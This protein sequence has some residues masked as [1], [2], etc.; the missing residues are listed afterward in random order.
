MGPISYYIGAVLYFGNIFGC[1]HDN[2]HGYFFGYN[3]KQIS[4]IPV[5]ENDDDIQ[6]GED[7][8]GELVILWY[9]LFATCED[10]E[11]STSLTPESEGLGG[12]APAKSRSLSIFF[13]AF[14]R[15][16]IFFTVFHADQ[17]IETWCWW[18]CSC[19]FDPDIP[20]IHIS[21]FV[22][23]EPAWICEGWGD[24]KTR[25]TLVWREKVYALPTKYDMY[26]RLINRDSS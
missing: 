11:S 26:L 17:I 5:W 10:E 22:F 9:C 7:G 2:H 24:I 25:C 15:C 6:T 19:S 4:F 1:D 20:M 21:V 14:H 13:D 18:W 3:Y 12:S 23:P 8:D 16:I